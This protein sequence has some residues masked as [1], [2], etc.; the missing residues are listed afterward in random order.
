MVKMFVVGNAAASKALASVLPLALLTP[1]LFAANML[2]ARW[3]ES[4]GIPPFLLAFGRWSLAVFLLLPWVFPRLK[5]WSPVIRANW[6]QFSALAVLGMAVAVGPQYVGAR[7][8]T[9]ANMALIF[10][11]CPVIVGVIEVLGWKASFSRRRWWGMLISL[12]GIIVVLTRG[13]V[14]AW[15][16]VRFGGGDVWVLFAAVG[17]A[18][19]TVL[20]KRFN[21]PPLPALVRLAVLA[22]GGALALAPFALL[23]SCTGL[24]ADFSDPRLYFALAVLAVVPSLGA[25]LCYERLIATAGAVGA[26]VSMYL[27]PLYAS[28]LAWPLLGEIPRWH[29]ALGFILVLIGML[30]S[31]W[32][33]RR[34]SYA[35][36]P[37]VQSYQ[38]LHRSLRVQP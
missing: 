10:S 29:Q 12:A 15:V 25:Y 5:V 35:R 37:A 9:A 23:E 17:W 7:T 33:G 31:E 26:S 22:A 28:L 6:V 1:A 20:G 34:G 27:V 13:D 14:S 8:T 4:A 21:L 32:Q 38:T 18:L 36:I 2:T 19:Y 24:R 11:A 30:V 3:A 16:G